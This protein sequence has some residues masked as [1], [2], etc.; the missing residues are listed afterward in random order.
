MV[1]NSNDNKGWSSIN[2]KAWNSIGKTALNGNDEKG[3]N[4]IDMLWNS[5]KGVE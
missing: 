4:S 5:N 2:M 1:S 3:W